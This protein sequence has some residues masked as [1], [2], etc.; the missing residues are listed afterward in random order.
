MLGNNDLT[1]AFSMRVIVGR[2]NP[3]DTVPMVMSA[4]IHKFQRPTISRYA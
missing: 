4:P 3:A 2:H 1:D